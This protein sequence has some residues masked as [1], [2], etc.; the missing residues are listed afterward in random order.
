MI[1]GW[2][3]RTIAARRARILEQQRVRE[4]IDELKPK[5]LRKLAALD[6]EHD[7]EACQAMKRETL[8]TARRLGMDTRGGRVSDTGIW[9]PVQENGA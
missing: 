5:V 3:R 7:P 8:E 4:E 2:F 6:P 9:R 1:F